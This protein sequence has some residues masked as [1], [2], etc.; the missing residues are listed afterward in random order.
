MTNKYSS[1][2]NLIIKHMILFN[3]FIITI[4]FVLDSIHH[5][6]DNTFTN[7]LVNVKDNLWRI[8][9][10]LKDSNVSPSKKQRKKKESR[11]AP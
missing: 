10:S 9:N 3:I 1:S 5:V 4:S 7:V 8:P 11:H 2:F 6:V